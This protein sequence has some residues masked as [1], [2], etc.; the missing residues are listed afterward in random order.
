M[1]QKYQHAKSTAVLS[2]QHGEKHSALPF[3]SLVPSIGT[4]VGCVSMLVGSELCTPKR[5]LMPISV[6]ARFVS[7][8]MSRGYSLQLATANAF[9]N[10]GLAFSARAF[11]KELVI[12]GGP[13]SLSQSV[14]GAPSGRAFQS[15]PLCHPLVSLSAMNVIRSLPFSTEK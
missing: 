6:E 7:V 4:D 2:C 12:P 8:A 14:N 11:S 3:A 1:R 10:P 5:C 9:A 13:P 15:P